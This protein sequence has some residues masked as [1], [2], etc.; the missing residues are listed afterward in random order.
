MLGNAGWFWN[1]GKMLQKIKNTGI[2]GIFQYFTAFTCLYTSIPWSESDLTCPG[3]QKNLLLD[4]SW[5]RPSGQFFLS[6]LDSWL[7][8]VYFRLE[9]KF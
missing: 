2:L 8:Y 1:M 4:L 6:F 3:S 7:N 9:F 5:S